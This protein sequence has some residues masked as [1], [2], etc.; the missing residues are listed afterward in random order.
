MKIVKYAVLFI[1]AAVLLYNSIYFES[2]SEHQ[3]TQEPAEFNSP[4]YGLEFWK[5]LQHKLID[6]VPAPTL[7]ALLHRD[8]QTAI[9]KYGRTLGVSSNHSYLLQGSGT[10]LKITD[11]AL[12]VSIQPPATQ[13]DVAIATAFI[14]GNDIR[15]ASGLVAVS[16]FPST[17]EFNTISSEINKMVSNTVLPPVLARAQVGQRIRFGAATTVSEDDPQL[18]PLRIVPITLEIVD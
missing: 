3:A 6:A 17:M 2:L 7:L 9:T 10:L 11:D 18:T 5:K 16:D 4:R 8:M 1:I 14:F 15:D 12:L 13:A